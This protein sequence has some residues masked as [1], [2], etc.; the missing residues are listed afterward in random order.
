MPPPRAPSPDVGTTPLPGTGRAS[1]SAIVPQPISFTGSSS[2]TGAPVVPAH[3]P[4]NINPNAPIP[5]YKQPVPAAAPT[6]GGAP[7][8]RDRSL[9]PSSTS[10]SVP[11]TGFSAT[12]PRGGRKSSNPNSSSIVLI[13]PAHD[14]PNSQPRY[15]ILDYSA[16]A[17]T[18]QYQ[19]GSSSLSLEAY[20]QDATSKGI[21]VG[22]GGGGKVGEGQ[23]TA[24]WVH[25]SYSASSDPRNEW[26]PVV[27]AIRQLGSFRG[28]GNKKNIGGRTFQK[29]TL[30]I[31]ESGVGF[32]IPVYAEDLS[33]ED[34][35][36]IGIQ[37]S[38]S[39]KKWN[40][41][42]GSTYTYV[43]PE[44]TVLEALSRVEGRTLKRGRMEFR[45]EF[46]RGWRVDDIRMLLLTTVSLRDPEL[47]NDLFNDPKRGIMPTANVH[48]D[49]TAL[50][51]SVLRSVIEIMA[52]VVTFM[53]DAFADAEGVVF[54]KP[55]VIYQQGGF[56][57]ESE[58]PRIK[59][60]FRN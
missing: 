48:T 56:F 51:G 32:S 12:R 37:R 46:I 6:P 16:E 59:H 58:R 47:E 24:R 29:Q 41:S 50:L 53:E 3:V 7:I 54:M 2:S 13:P 30:T 4:T 55:A 42:F 15:A 38:P 1:T 45:I 28:A 52:E 17:G 31:D 27:K 18:G 14:P 44:S 34:P 36:V 23:Q 43:R 57:A 60:C 5:S 22:K 26:G 40:E 9:S 10:L 35:Q 21:G 11:G 25:C 19:I 39:S 49:G 20:L 33:S 8:P